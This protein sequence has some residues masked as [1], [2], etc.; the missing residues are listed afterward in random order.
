MATESSDARVLA[1]QEQAVAAEVPAVPAAQEGSSA[2]A[3]QTESHLAPEQQVQETVMQAGSPY[4]VV[5]SGELSDPTAIQVAA[6]KQQQAMYTGF[7]APYALNSPSAMAA[8]PGMVPR[9]G[10]PPPLYLY[11]G[12]QAAVPLT[13]SFYNGPSSISGPCYYDP[14]GMLNPAAC[15]TPMALAPTDP[16]ASA[17]SLSQKNSKSRGFCC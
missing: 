6:I 13:T 1:G 4:R 10:H 2:E 12:A 5:G 17:K 14:Y 11:P 7:G 9:M 15:F 3:P 8:T 16:A